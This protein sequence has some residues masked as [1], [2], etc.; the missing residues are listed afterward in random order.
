[1]S[2]RKAIVPEFYLNKQRTKHDAFYKLRMHKSLISTSPLAV[3]NITLSSAEAS[4]FRAEYQKLLT[5]LEYDLQFCEDPADM[6]E[7]DKKLTQLK[8]EIRVFEQCNP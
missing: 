1:M 7:L 6:L 4:V 8:E 2:Y 3:I 5:Q